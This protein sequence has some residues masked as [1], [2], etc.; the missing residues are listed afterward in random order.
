MVEFCNADLAQLDADRSEAMAS[1]PVLAAASASAVNTPSTLQGL[2]S[3]AID[4]KGGD[5]EDGSDVSWQSSHPSGNLH[6]QSA[7]TPSCV[8]PST[9]TS[10]GSHSVT[11]LP[12]HSCQPSGPAEVSCA[13]PSATFSAPDVSEAPRGLCSHPVSSTSALSCR[14]SHRTQEG[15]VVREG[16][17]L[18]TSDVSEASTDLSSHPVDEWAYVSCHSC[19]T[20]TA[21]M[22]SSSSSASEDSFD[23]QPSMSTARCVDS[24]LGKSVLS[25]SHHLFQQLGKFCHGVHLGKHILLGMLGRFA[26]AT[27]ATHH[28]TVRQA[29]LAKPQAHVT[30]LVADCSST[31]VPEPSS[32]GGCADAEAVTS[33]SPSQTLVK[34]VVADSVHTVPAEGTDEEQTESTADYRYHNCHLTQVGLPV[35]F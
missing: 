30:Q 6:A 24:D 18:S 29:Q 11:S 35:V 28:Q 9:S 14:S 34:G 22:S 23:A 3:H 27:K 33:H 25:E 2:S 15:A 1:I 10:T 8:C 16:G 31:S 13:G 7:D 5:K 32:A 26:A 17:P 12:A 20:S 4:S 19:N 21:S